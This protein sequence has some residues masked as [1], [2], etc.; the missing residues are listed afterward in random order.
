MCCIAGRCH[1][2]AQS[3]CPIISTYFVGLV[4]VVCLTQDWC[5]SS[6]RPP[7]SMRASSRC[8]LPRTT[9][10]T[11]A[12]YF[13]RWPVCECV[14]STCTFF[15]SVFVLNRWAP[16]VRGRFAAECRWPRTPFYSNMG[17][18]TAIESVNP[19][20]DSSRWPAKHISFCTR[21]KQ[22][23]VLLYRRQYS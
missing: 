3:M 8:H 4:G 5:I 20:A 16:I 17:A 18:S 10:L 21:S 6:R 22:L 1:E 12:K 2:R 14:L 7:L 13:S 15:P 19:A 9:S 11:A 23:L